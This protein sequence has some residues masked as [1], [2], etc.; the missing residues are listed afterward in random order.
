MN[1][2]IAIAEPKPDHLEPAT[3]LVGPDC[4]DLRKI[5]IGI[6]IDDD[7]CR[8]DSVHDLVDR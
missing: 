1:H 3:R 6:E 8:C 2:D 7:H 5:C 4:Q